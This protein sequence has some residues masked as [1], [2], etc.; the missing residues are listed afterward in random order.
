VSLPVDVRLALEQRFRLGHGRVVAALTRRFGVERFA[1]VEQ[2]V[3][4]AYVRALERWPLAGMPD[5]PERWLVRVAHN[6]TV[7]TLRREPPSGV[8]DG[9][10]D[11]PEE[12]PAPDDE[13]ELRL[14]FLCCE[15]NLARAAQVALVLNVAFGLSARQIANAFL[16][17]E[18]TV[19]QR[20]VRAKQR[21]RDTG[22]RFD[23]PVADALPA[24]LAAT[25]DVLY[26]V[27][28]EGYNPTGSDAAL[29]V[30]LCNEA[31]RL[32]RLLTTSEHTAAPATFA[33]RALLCFHAS[34]APARQADDG[35][36]L[37][38]PEQD[39]ARW[40]ERLMAE[41]FRC[42]DAAGAGAEL[43]RFHVEAGIAACHALA[44]SYA[45]TDWERVVDLYDLL[46]ACAPSLVVDVNR[47][48]AVA[49]QS[50]ARAGLDELDA[51]PEREVL[52][53]YPYALAAYADLN[54]S[55]G[56]LQEA[57]DYLDRALQQQAAPAQQA[58]L[59]RKRAALD[60]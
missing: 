21:L 59:R 42:L 18:R 4:D 29:D 3:Q 38:L 12:P 30:G 48:W 47:A 51:I 34:R 26:L 43:T 40:D 1:L 60:R 20:I 15:P 10:E 46:R 17:D 16:S 49:M 23:L 44:T 11:R 5:D 57:R 13:D 56:N 37:L 19:A 32:V 6:A 22:V 9:G 39:R 45:T 31:L 35:S 54:A 41:A 28:S 52:G 55:L 25:L 24:R 36:L 2:A 33:L 50:G 8:L 58:L 14:V 7:D 53:R 27:F